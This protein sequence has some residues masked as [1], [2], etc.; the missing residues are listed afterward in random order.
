MSR[1]AVSIHGGGS[2]A[3]TLRVK[4]SCRADSSTLLI[5]GRSSEIGS[6]VIVF[7]LSR[8]GHLRADCVGAG[9]KRYFK[10]RY[11]CITRCLVWSSNIAWRG[12][13]SG[14]YVAVKCRLG[15][16]VTPTKPALSCDSVPK[17]STLPGDD[18]IRRL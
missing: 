9:W 3:R 11:A 17:K 14:K 16:I 2:R 10:F 7:G 13:N 8:H 12:W 5:C 6:I 18:S 15:C 4:S 1:Y